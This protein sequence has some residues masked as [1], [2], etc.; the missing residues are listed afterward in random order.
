MLRAE[1]AR[2]AFERA[3]DRRREARRRRSFR[4]VALERLREV[5]TAPVLGVLPFPLAARFGGVALTLADRLEVESRSRPVAL[6]AF[7]G[8]GWRLELAAESRRAAAEGPL[9]RPLAAADLDG[10]DACAAIERAADAVGAGI[11]HVENLDRMPL[12]G[13]A[14]LAARRTLVLSTHDF[15]LYCPNVQLLEAATGRFC[16]YCRALDRCRCCL[17]ASPGAGGVDPARHRAAAGEL[18]AA[19]AAVVHPS[20]FMRRAH[21]DL[22]PAA[23]PRREVVI[24]PAIAIAPPRAPRTPLAP[25]R[26]VAF[27]GQAAER[28]GIADFEQAAVA[29]APGHPG[30][31]WLALG[32]GEPRVVARLRQAGIRALGAYRAGGGARRLVEHRIDL[33]VLPSRFPEAHCLALDECLVAGVPVVA[34]DLGALGERVR[35][36][37]AG[38]TVAAAEGALATALAAAL[39]RPPAPAAARAS[40]APLAAAAAAH[41]EL[42]DALGAARRSGP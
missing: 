19:A 8:A 29:L 10:L 35:A 13:L 20:D 30:V 40:A 7:D 34:A 2:G 15:A 26:R 24:A 5:G 32:G 17:A 33:A 4:P 38:V 12:A 31:E 14:R 9:A 39:A 3:V 28:K 22:F 41:R 6:L 1:G 16:G 42:Y 25:P 11:V 21:R 27:F 23:A 18:V 36:L 37:G